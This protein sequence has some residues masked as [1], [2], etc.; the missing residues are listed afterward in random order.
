MASAPDRR[1]AWIPWAFVAFMGVVVAVNGVM[2]YLALSTFTGTTVD[3]AYERGRLYNAVLAEAERQAAFG[4]RFEVRWTP[5]G[6]PHAGRL[7]VAAADRHGAPLEGLVIEGTVTR[8]LGRPEPIPLALS[9]TGS[10]RY[11][12]S[13]TL[14][15]AGQWEVRLAARRGSEGPVEFRERI[16]VR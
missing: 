9:Q 7:V 14:G 13:F 16:I 10:G 4:W 6:E 8:P 2:V 12:A 15:G 5:A 3:R 11:G 1:S